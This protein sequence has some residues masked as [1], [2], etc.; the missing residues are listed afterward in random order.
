MVWEMLER[1]V[2]FSKMGNK[3]IEEKVKAG[4]RPAISAKYRSLEHLFDNN[5]H[6]PVLVK[7][8]E[9]CWSQDALERPS[10]YEVKEKLRPFWLG[11]KDPYDWPNT[12]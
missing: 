10:F 5:K 7:L 3:E 6:Y 1:K 11:I 4:E 8:I 2:P 12:T 9:S